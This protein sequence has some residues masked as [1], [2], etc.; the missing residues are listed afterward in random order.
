MWQAI[1]SI[2][3]NSYKLL[4][5]KLLYLVVFVGDDGDGDELEICEY[6]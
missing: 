4:Q 3:G 2:A 1:E 6:T 5:R